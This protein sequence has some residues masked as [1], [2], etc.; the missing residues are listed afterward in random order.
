[1]MRSRAAWLTAALLFS[2]AAAA[3]SWPVLQ[4]AQCDAAIAATEKRYP[5][6]HGLL[7]AIARV[8]S[9]RPITAA[10]DIRA[11]PWAID[12]E[13][14]GLFLDSKAAAIAWVDQAHRR[15]VQVIDVGCLQVNLFY[16]PTAFADLDQAFDP[17]ANADYAARFLLDLYR[18]PAGHSWPIAVG[19]YHSGTPELAEEYRG[20]VA[21]DGQG[22][23]TGIGGPQPLYLRGAMHVALSGG[24]HLILHVN[25]Q[26]HLASMKPMNRCRAAAL[27]APLLARPPSTAGC[28][29]TFK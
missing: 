1:M 13:G 17:L 3:A 9:G 14:R 8:E 10:N 4:S 22:I 26:P 28:G 7:A 6:P 29:R 21:A 25:R 11:W 16:H 23:I 5:L 2:H 12:A 19:L 18:G 20:R 27:L 15:G 24:G